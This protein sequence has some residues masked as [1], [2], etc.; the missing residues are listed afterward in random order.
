MEVSKAPNWYNYVAP[1]NSDVTLRSSDGDL[2]RMHS[3]ILSTSS[4]WFRR[5]LS[6]IRVTDR[7]CR[8][9]SFPL[10]KQDEVAEPDGK[11]DEGG[12]EAAKKELFNYGVI[13]LLE[14]SRVLQTFLK[15]VSGAAID[16]W[17]R[18]SEVY[19][20]AMVAYK[21]EAQGILS[22]I[23]MI[24]DTTLFHNRPLRM[25]A[26]ADCMDWQ[27]HAQTAA[28]LSLTLSIH[29]ETHLP[30]LQRVQ[31]HGLIRLFNLHDRRKSAFRR[32]LASIARPAEKEGLKLRRCQA[33][34]S[35]RKWLV[36]QMRMIAEIEQRPLGDTVLE[37]KFMASSEAQE[38]W[39]RCG[40][41]C[42]YHY[43]KEWVYPALEACIASLPS[44]L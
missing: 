39:M 19:T 20:L 28:T 27:E 11:A 12:D 9:S 16:P 32:G 35:K 3:I 43:E 25:Y 37:D 2:F 8:L 22:I 7:L 44:K 33:G 21:Y 34:D 29:D 18:D 31:G 15:M 26:M 14:R 42:E 40:S 23:R 4:G 13:D 41:C 36:L 17:R 5:R 24:A 10:G 38:C 30:F 6:S 1:E